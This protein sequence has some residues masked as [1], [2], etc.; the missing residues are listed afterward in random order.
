[1]EAR[2][3]DGEVFLRDVSELDGLGTRCLVRAQDTGWIDIHAAREARWHALDVAGARPIVVLSV[4]RRLLCAHGFSARLVWGRP[5]RRRGVFRTARP[6]RCRL[7]RPAMLGAA[8]LRALG[9]ERPDGEPLMS[10]FTCSPCHA[11][12]VDWSVSHQSWVHAWD[13]SHPGLLAQLFIEWETVGEDDSTGLVDLRQAIGRYGAPAVVM[14][15]L[16]FRYHELLGPPREGLAM[17]RRHVRRIRSA[18]ERLRPGK[19]SPAALALHREA[20]YEALAD[21]LDTPTAFLALFDWIREARTCRAH[22]VGD[23]D[24]RAML[25]L[26][27]MLPAPRAPARA[28]APKLAS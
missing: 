15:L 20:F 22:T 26:L 7:P 4:L 12:L 25:G 3:I 19:P 5:D 21:D 28:V 10:R 6:P 27:A 16:A 24:L 8:E 18:L 1:M 23:R 14:Y 2:A 13:E 11:V 17:A 9:F